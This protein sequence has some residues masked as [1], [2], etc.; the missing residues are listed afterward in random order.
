MNYE[1]RLGS[2]SIETTV[3]VVS[4]VRVWF[5]PLGV[6][7]NPCKRVQEQTYRKIGFCEQISSKLCQALCSEI[8]VRKMFIVSLLEKYSFSVIY[9]YWSLGDQSVKRLIERL[10]NASKGSI[11]VHFMKHSTGTYCKSFGLAN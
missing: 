9:C 4:P 1:S 8:S 10:G 5:T 7:R 6:G 2:P 3:N 11:M